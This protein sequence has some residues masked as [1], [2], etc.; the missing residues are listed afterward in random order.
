MSEEQKTARKR[1]TRSPA[2]VAEKNAMALERVKKDKVSIGVG[3]S[4][5]DRQLVSRLLSETA[6][7][8]HQRRVENDEQLKQRLDQYFTLCQQEAIIPTVEEMYL[9][10]GY[11]RQWGTAVRSGRLRGF[12]VNTKHILDRACEIMAAFD[13]KLVMTGRMNNVTYIFR[14]KNYHGMRDEQ[15]VV[16]EA[17]SENERE[18]SAEEIARRYLG[19]LKVV[20]AEFTDSEQKTTEGAQN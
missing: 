18:Q 1:R 4:E 20:D 13:A 8:Y 5:E 7:A 16:I 17:T 19:D 12:S 6:A 2:T 15:N 9:Y 14:S 11:S 3:S 10:T